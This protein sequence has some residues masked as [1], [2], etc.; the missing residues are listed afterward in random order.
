MK[1][2]AR[3]FKEKVTM[4]LKETDVMG[5]KRKDADGLEERPEVC[6][7]PPL[8]QNN[9]IPTLLEK[10]K[11]RSGVGRWKQEKDTEQAIKARKD[12]KVSK[13]ETPLFIPTL[14]PL[15]KAGGNERPPHT[16]MQAVGGGTTNEPPLWPLPGAGGTFSPFLFI[17][18]KPINR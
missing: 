3:E 2:D 4:G 8:F 12:E 13:P 11:G 9:A 6:C 18:P 1:K 14:L 17:N 10:G 5:F 15:P 16:V 7:N